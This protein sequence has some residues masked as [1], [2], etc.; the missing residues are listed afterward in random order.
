MN[1]T[2]EDVV[3]EAR[4]WL[5]TPFHDCADVKGA[6]VDCAMMLVRVFV[7]LGVVPPFDPRPY[8]PQWFLH[9]SE[10]RFLNWMRKLARP[11]EVA[12]AGD[13][14]LFSFGHQAAH[15]AII[16]DDDSM[17][18]AYLPAGRVILDSRGALA[19]CRHSYWSAF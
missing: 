8:Y 13:V 18:H 16:V 2:R 1:V 17:V 9:S 14:V 4:S 10:S 15:G 12:Q 3:R 7:D 6:G 19:H 5:G 11:I